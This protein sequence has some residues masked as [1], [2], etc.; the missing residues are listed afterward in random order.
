[1]ARLHEGDDLREVS[2]VELGSEIVEAQDRPLP[3]LLRVPASL[4]EQAGQCT[5][6]FLAARE[7]FAACRRRKRYGPVR[8]M[9]AA[10][11]ESACKVAIAPTG[12]HIAEI[13]VRFPAI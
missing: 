1:I 11:R 8:P 2:R 9:R 12:E 13:A 4:G 5:Q 3:A 7:M 10:A 6:F